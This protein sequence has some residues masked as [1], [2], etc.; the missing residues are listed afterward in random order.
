MNINDRR[1]SR[2]TIAWSQR[3]RLRGSW[4]AESEEEIRANAGMERRKSGFTIQ[5]YP[6]THGTS[7]RNANGHEGL[8]T[9]GLSPFERF[10]A[11]V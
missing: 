8:D 1:A 4:C 7:T 10:A 9:P 5:W 3:R 6:T 2:V 11:T